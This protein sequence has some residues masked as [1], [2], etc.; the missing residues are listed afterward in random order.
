M[1][2]DIHTLSEK[3][4]EKLANSIFDR[5]TTNTNPLCFSQKEILIVEEWI[6]EIISEL[7]IKQ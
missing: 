7:M 4:L 3:L 2:M 5:D 1:S 6:R